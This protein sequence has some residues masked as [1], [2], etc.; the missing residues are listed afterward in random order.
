MADLVTTLT[1]LDRR[2]PVRTARR[3]TDSEFLAF[4]RA[5]HDGRLG[6]EKIVLLGGGAGPT[7]SPSLTQWLN[8]HPQVST[9]VCVG[10]EEWK[11]RVVDSLRPSEP[12]R[13]SQ[14]PPEGVPGFL[15]A[16]SEWSRDLDGRPRPFAWTQGPA[17]PSHRSPP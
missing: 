9:E 7:L 17:L 15:H 8:R 4:L 10:T 2:E 6:E 11:Q 1:L 14:T 16:V 13:S 12:G 3:Y 5:V